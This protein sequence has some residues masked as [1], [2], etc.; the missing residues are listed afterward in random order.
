MCDYSAVR[1]WLIGMLAFAALA[2]SSVIFAIS[3]QNIPIWGQ[4]VSSASF[5]IAA[6][7]ASAVVGSAISA[8]SALT[9]FCNCTAA[10]P[11][12]ASACKSLNYW[13]GLIV[14]TAGALAVFSGV[15][16][17]YSVAHLLFWAVTL[18]AALTVM[19]VGALAFSAQLESCQ[20]TPAPPPPAAGA[21]PLTNEPR[22]PRTPQQSTGTPF[23]GRGLGDVIARITSF[24]GITPCEPCRRRA[25][26]LNR[27]LPLE[28][29]DTLTRT[30]SS[31]V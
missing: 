27:L 22:S 29:R 12:C 9:T 1:G 5:G 30:R 18:L 11:A 4:I 2:M 23:L 25:E 14:F 21:G 20:S 19:I 3:V 7:W 17:F 24:L 6:L 31:H 26:A 16:S 10:I 28:R 15:S 8:A 13:L